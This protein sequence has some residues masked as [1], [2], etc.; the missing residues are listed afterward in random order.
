MIL[1]L[2]LRL[3]RAREN[4][5]GAFMMIAFKGFS[6]QSI[7]KGP[8]F[9]HKRINGL[10]AHRLTLIGL[11]QKVEGWKVDN[12]PEISFKLDELLDVLSWLRTTQR[13]KLREVADK[14]GLSISFISDIE[15][16][17]VQPLLKTLSVLAAAY[18]TPLM[19]RL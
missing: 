11:I 6:I 10:K 19:L 7:V 13:M 3:E 14:T 17:R 9:K 15:H 8:Y 16:G 1:F 5:I 2:M 4:I 18:G 12:F